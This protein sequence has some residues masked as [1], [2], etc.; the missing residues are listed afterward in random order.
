MNYFNPLVIYIDFIIKLFMLTCF[1]MQTIVARRLEKAT[2]NNFLIN[3]SL[4]I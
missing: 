3:G 2:N 4:K 1:K